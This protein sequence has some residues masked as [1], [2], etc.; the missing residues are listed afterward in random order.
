MELAEKIFF[1]IKWRTYLNKSSNNAQDCGIYEVI[2][3]V[4]RERSIL[5]FRKIKKKTDF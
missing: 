4:Q 3:S 5:F 2:Q 1:Y